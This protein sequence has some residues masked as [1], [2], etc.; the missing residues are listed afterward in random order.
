MAGMQMPELPPADSRGGRSQRP[1][2]KSWGQLTHHFLPLA[3]LP[4]S[5]GLRVKEQLQQANLGALVE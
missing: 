1:W 4:W 3:E 2:Y 5:G